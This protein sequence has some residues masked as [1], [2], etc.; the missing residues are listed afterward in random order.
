MIEWNVGLAD[1]TYGGND[2]PMLGDQCEV[3]V[4]EVV[5]ELKA[6]AYAG[7]TVL[8]LQN[9]G[10]IVTANVSFAEDSEEVIKLALGIDGNDLTDQVI[11]KF[12]QGKELIFHPRSAGLDKSK[13]IV[14]YNACIQGNLTRSYTNNQTY[15]TVSF[16]AMPK[17]GYDLSQPD[18]FFRIGQ[19]S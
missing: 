1:V 13:D 7:E 3:R 6:P 10:Y 9:N 14:I 11:G 4:E 18:N 12:K 2:L 19:S 16:T 8:G 15:I 17:E 5:Q